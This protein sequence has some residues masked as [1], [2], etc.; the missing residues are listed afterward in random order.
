M[1]KKRLGKSWSTR[2]DEAGEFMELSMRL[3]FGCAFT[4]LAGILALGLASQLWAGIGLLLCLIFCPLGFLVGFFWLEV[5]F[6]LRLLL[7]LVIGFFD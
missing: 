2:V 4:V 5:K 1:E 7:S 6:F 3:L